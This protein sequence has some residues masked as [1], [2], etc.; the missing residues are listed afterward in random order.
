[1]D[2]INKRKCNELGNVTKGNKILNVAWEERMGDTS[3]RT[4]REG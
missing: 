3:L 2:I 1:M 4:G